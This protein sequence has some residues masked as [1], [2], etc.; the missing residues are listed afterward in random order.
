MAHTPPR[1][2]C[3]YCSRDVNAH[4]QAEHLKCLIR[5]DPPAITSHQLT[6]AE[7]TPTG[8]RRRDTT[9]AGLSL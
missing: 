2:N 1:Q 5:L 6:T 9:P 3:G 8:D 4:T 7:H